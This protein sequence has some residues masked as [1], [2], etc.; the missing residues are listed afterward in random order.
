ML[1]ISI[2]PSVAALTIFDAM[3]P[4]AFQELLQLELE[5]LSL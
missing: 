3:P 4:L 2:I 5:L 1:S